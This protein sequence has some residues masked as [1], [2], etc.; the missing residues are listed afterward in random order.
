M[1]KLLIT[2]DGQDFAVNIEQKP[3]VRSNY[4][5][6]VDGIDVEVYVPPP[7]DFANL[8]WI[9]VDRRP[10]EIVVDRELGWIQSHVGRHP[11]EIHDL[12]A[13]VVRPVSGDGRVKAPIP[14]LIARV[15]VEPE[16]AVEIGEPLVVLEAMKM[17]NEVRSPRAGRVRQINVTAG[18]T[19]VQEEL[20]MEIE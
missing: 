1:H 10:Y 6:Q 4:T 19:V 2:I 14:G 12:Q 17:E 9:V 18:Q 7:G 11:V 20:M 3:G 13:T 5:V 8:E 15:L 16:Q